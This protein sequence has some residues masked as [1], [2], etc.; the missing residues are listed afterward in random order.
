MCPLAHG[1]LLLER[2]PSGDTV[3]HACRGSVLN[4]PYA[5]ME[6][7]SLPRCRVWGG[8]LTG[9][10]LR[11]PTSLVSQ[12][13]DLGHLN[14][15]PVLCPNQYRPRSAGLLARGSRHL[16]REQ[17]SRSRDAVRNDSPQSYTSLPW[18]L[19]NADSGVGALRPLTGA[20][21]SRPQLGA[22]SRPSPSSPA[23]CPRTHPHLAATLP[24]TPRAC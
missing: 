15:A 11:A 12:G 23:P 5:D 4:V 19:P 17:S 18:G 14:R 13:G 2:P 1:D 7:R 3:G 22:E 6:P 16:D 10:L 21:L 20:R 9:G 8:V 24:G